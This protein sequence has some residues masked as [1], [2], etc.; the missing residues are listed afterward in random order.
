M[1]TFLHSRAAPIAVACFAIAIFAGMDTVMKALSIAIGPYNALLWRSVLGLTLT[2]TLY[3]TMRRGAF[4]SRTTL[5]LHLARGVAAATSILLFFWGLVRVPLAQGIALSF[6]APLIGLG[7][8]ALFLKERVTRHAL[9]GSVLAFAGVLIVVAG[10]PQEAQGEQAFAG[11]LAI[12][13]AAIFYAINLVLSRRQSQSAGP[14]EVGFFFNLVALCFF[15]I[16]APW[17]GE[18]PAINHWPGLLLAACTSTVSIMLLSWAYARAEAQVLMPVEYTAFIWA[19][20]LGWWAFGEAVTPATF[21]G[22]A[23]IIA[24]CLWASRPAARLHATD[25]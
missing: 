17:L 15:G 21:G 14:I 16:G 9:T 10:Q 12:L 1:A 5:L 7:L 22:A 20:L 3:A 6:I 25:S 13:S 11:A 23:L 18:V 24:G 19:A 8:A 4:P 2:G